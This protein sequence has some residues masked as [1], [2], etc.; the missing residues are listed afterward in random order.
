L[1]I[2]DIFVL[3][4][5]KVK[6]GDPL[7]QLDTRSL[8]AQKKTAFC[9]LQAAMITYE[10]AKIQFSF[11][12][13]LQDKRAV[14]EKDYDTA[15]YNMKE[16][17]E[18]VNIAKAVVDQ[19]ET[20]IKRATVRAPVDGEILQVN[21]HVGEIYPQN[22]YNVTQSYVNL[23]TSL[24]LMGKVAPLQMRIDI[25][26]EDAWRYRPGS[27]ATAF[28]R[29]NANISFPLEYIRVEPYIL[30]KVSFTGSNV[31]RID[32]RVLQ[33]LYSFEKDNIPVY[34]GQLLDVYL[35]TPPLEEEE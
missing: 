17:E 20:D 7:L 9:Q 24:I 4:G 10:N 19:V 29:G 3:E 26:E 34:P 32:T 8:E 13:R 14:S 5:N 15:Y 30:P 28:V 31:E 16:A 21:A 23:P 6:A 35:E 25:D 18:Q 11:Y 33:V 2:T 12:E 1:P 27:K 22:S